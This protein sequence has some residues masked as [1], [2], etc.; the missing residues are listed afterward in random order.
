MDIKIVDEP[1]ILGLSGKSLDLFQD[2]MF[3]EILWDSQVR[4]DYGGSCE[5]TVPLELPVRIRRS[6]RIGE[7]SANLDTQ[8]D[9]ELIYQQDTGKITSAH[10]QDMQNLL[11]IDDCD[12][13]VWSIDD[14]L[15]HLSV[16]E[17]DFLKERLQE[18]GDSVQCTI[19]EVMSFLTQLYLTP[20]KDKIQNKIREIVGYEHV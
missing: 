17:R 13:D 16:S 1:Y 5:K 19:E 11:V 15:S 12:L 9:Y 18:T 6:L 4:V 14:E 2:L 20:L 10:I 3:E 8:I 7:Q